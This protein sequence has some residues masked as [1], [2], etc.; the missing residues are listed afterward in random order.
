MDTYEILQALT[1]SPGV[2]GH[3]APA[4]AVAASY[5][6]RF[7]DQ[8]YTDVFG[9]LYGSMGSGHPVVLVCAH[10]DEIG[11]MVDGITEDGRLHLCSIAGV[12]PRVLPGSRVY[13][14]AAEGNIPAVVGAMPPHLLQDKDKEAAYKIEELLLDTGLPVETVR[15]RIR[16]GDPIC[17]ALSSPVKLKNGRVAGKSMD[18]R[19]LVAAE[20]LA[21]EMLSKRKF[22]GTAVFCATTQEERGCLGAGVSGYRVSPDIA[23]AMDVTHAPTPGAAAFETVDFDKIAIA[24][25]GNIHPAIAEALKKLAE[26]LSIPYT[27]EADMFPTGTD[28]RT[29]QVQRGGV[30]TGLIELPLRYMHTSVECLDLDTL[31]NCARMLTEY[32]AALDA[33]WA[34]PLLAAMEVEE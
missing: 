18:D 29:L 30:P 11:M 12:D 4:S 7:A 13:I 9:N 17:F 2:T 21:M 16:V 33:D 27:I 23:I 25:G 32:L 22:Q 24:V 20:I 3:E 14:L 15:A 8:V 34:S 26:E 19:A 1:T 10:T 28:A 5:F 31:K 6:R